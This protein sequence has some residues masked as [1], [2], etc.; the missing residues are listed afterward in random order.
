MAA[1]LYVAGR[2]IQPSYTFSMLGADPIPVKSLL[3]TIALALAGTQVLLALWIYRKL[4]LAASPPRPVPVVHRVTGFALFAV[5]VPVAVHRGWPSTRS[6]LLLLRRV[7][8]QGAARA[9]QA[10]A[11]LGAASGGRD[12]PDR[13]RRAVV[14]QRPPAPRLLT[15]VGGGKLW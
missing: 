1:A 6:R 2:L 8:R 7:R 12:A 11:R 4:P 13:H 14:L 10:A 3:A 5:T 15:N 9:Q